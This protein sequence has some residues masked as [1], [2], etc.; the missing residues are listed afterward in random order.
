MRGTAVVGVVVAG[1]QRE[2]A[3]DDPALDL[4]AE[5]LASAVRVHPLER[6][7]AGGAMSVA[8]AVEAGEVR[9]RFT[10]GQHVVRGDRGLDQGNS[11]LD[12]LGARRLEGTEGPPIALCRVLVERRGSDFANRADLQA[13]D[14]V[15]DRFE[16]VLDRQVA[17]S[18]IAGIGAGDRAE[19]QCGVADGS[20]ERSDLVE[21]RGEGD[22]AVAGNAAVGRLDADDA[23]EGGRLPDGATGIGAQSQ[24]HFGG[25]DRRG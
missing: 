14:A 5:A 20:G 1:G 25:R 22:Q 18:R 8:A 16:V 12:Q 19:C 21:R 2:R 24:R 15:F 23:A 6:A 17:A 11:H 7:G 3:E 4:T 9:A 10:V 13:F